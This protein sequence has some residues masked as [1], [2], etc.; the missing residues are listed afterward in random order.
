MGGFYQGAYASP[1]KRPQLADAFSPDGAAIIRRA[2]VDPAFAA[3][4]GT[5]DGNPQP[6]SSS[7]AYSP[8][9]S[10]TGGAQPPSPGAV[11]NVS[12]AY[13]PSPPTSAKPAALVSGTDAFVQS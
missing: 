13:S 4:L 9:L 12:G 2:M 5:S 11:A 7:D 1:L 10:R 3:S 8:N 6:V